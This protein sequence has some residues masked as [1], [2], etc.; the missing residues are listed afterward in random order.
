MTHR[1]TTT[2][3]A[4]SDITDIATYIALDNP[5]AAYRFQEALGETLDSIARFPRRSRYAGRLKLPGQL[6][7]API[8]KPFSR[9]LLFFHLIDDQTVEIV[10]VLHGARDISQLLSKP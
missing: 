2:R 9:Y 5:D 7:V 10:R 8:I 1:I 3:L 4:A 6:R